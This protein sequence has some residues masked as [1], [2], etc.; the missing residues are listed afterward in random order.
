M[1][2]KNYII[3]EH[4]VVWP[5]SVKTLKTLHRVPPLVPKFVRTYGV[6]LAPCRQLGG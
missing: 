2:E 5:L 4:A 1:K 3:R 6:C